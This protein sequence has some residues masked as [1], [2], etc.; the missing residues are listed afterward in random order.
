MAPIKD[1]SY[2]TCNLLDTKYVSYRW[3]TLKKT[4]NV[5]AVSCFPVFS[6]IERQDTPECIRSKK[7]C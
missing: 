1:F 5:S 3:T 4:K 7:I 2:Q 6:L